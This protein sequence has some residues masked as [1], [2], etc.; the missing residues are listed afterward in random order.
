MILRVLI[1]LL[2]IV[3]C[4]SAQGVTYVVLWF[5]TED[6]IDP[7]SDNAAL[8]IATDLTNMGVR[9]TF[10]IVGEEARSLEQRGRTDV[11]RAISKHCIGYH[12]NWHSIQPTPAVYEQH[13]GL[14]EGAAEFERRERGGFE[15]VR[16]IFGK[17]PVCYGQ[18]G[19]SWAPQANLALRQWGV[20]VYLDDG[21]QVGLS[22]QPM[23][24]D[25]LLYVYNMGQYQMRADLGPQTPLANTF[26]QFDAAVRHFATTGGGLVSTYYHP[27]EFV[28]PE[29]W[30]AVN[31]PNGMTR[32]RD[33]WV[34][35]KRR[36][37]EDTEHCYQV[38][39][40]Y[41]EH[42]K[43]T[44]GVQFVTAEDLL[45]IY[46][47]PSAPKVDVGTL[48]RH[49]RQGVKFLSVDSGDLSAADILLQLLGLPSQYVDGPTR[50]GV[51]TYK[52]PVIPTSIFKRAFEDA[53]S[54]ITRNHRLPNEVFLGSQALSLTDFAATLAGQ[55]LS[56]GPIKLVQGRLDFEPF[57]S[58]DPRGSFKWPIDREDF[59]APE[60][61]ELARLQCWT[62]KP[63]RLVGQRAIR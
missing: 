58:H 26:L 14:L 63:A 19:S 38:L 34:Q 21:T 12:S 20:H 52:D 39:R 30:D 3:S 13:L 11:I 1:F 61:L 2:L 59:A 42:A 22:D 25:D 33:R 51:T 41:V 24:Y 17:T 9:A 8:R 40:S 15:D 6:Y 32:E 28:S 35:P 53:K 54:F 36:S 44:P 56:P 62:M 50:S 10:K 47:A 16:R 31:F 7:A 18:P 57:F 49:F 43:Q 5:D 55:V 37:A 45:R 46:S 29:Y 27:N 60:L 48:A 23:W 4:G